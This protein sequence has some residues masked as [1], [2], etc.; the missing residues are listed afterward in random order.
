M[1]GN[2]TIQRKMI[3]VVLAVAVAFVGIFS[4]ISIR[5][6]QGNARVINY[7]GVV[8]GGTQKLIKEELQGTQDDA[9]I[10]R[11]DDIIEELLTG[12]GELG[13]IRLNDK[14]FQSLMT[15]MKDRFQELKEAIMSVRQGGDK[16]ALFVISQEYFELADQTVTEAEQ[17]SEKNAEIAEIC[18]LAL[19]AFFIVVA[20]A[21][22]W[23]SSVQSKRQKVLQEAEAE[24]RKKQE[25]LSQMERAIQA[26]M[27][28]IS[29]LIYVSDLE[30]Y[31]LLF[32]NEAGKKTFH[33]DDIS[34]KKCYKVLQ[35]MDSP[36]SFCT[37]G[38]LKPG[39]NY[40]WE[41]TNPLTKCH[42]M[43]K[44]RLIEWD[45]RKARMEIAFD[46]TQVETEKEK[47]K[48][49]LDME[50]MVVECIRILYQG[51]DLDKA[52]DQVLRL[53]G[54]FLQAERT[55]I[56]SFKDD[57]LNNDYEWCR[58]GV[59]P[60]KEMLQN[61]PI[62]IIDR[63][64]PVFSE[65]KCVVIEDVEAYKDSSPEE[66]EALKVQNI[67]SL[68]VAPMETDGVLTGA[69][70][71]DNPPAEKIENISAP[72]QSLCYFLLLAYR[73]TENERQLSTLSFHDTLTSFYN[74]NK[75]MQDLEMLSRENSPVGIVY[76][77][78]NGLK[79]VNDRLGHS[80]GDRLLI[81]AADKMKSVF[82]KDDCYRVGG[83][84]FVII[85]LNI[86][87][88]MF[89]EKVA[90]LRRS[91]EYEDECRAAIGSR[92]SDSAL[93]INQIVA[94][95]DAS[96]Y[97][98][99]KLFYR[100]NKKAGR[101][102]HHS[103]EVLQLANPVVLQGEI[104]KQQFVVYLQPKISSSDRTAVGAEALIRYLSKDG[105]L[106]LPGH[107]L[108]VLEEAKTISQIDFYVFDLVCAKI[109]EWL[110]GG[111]RSVPVSVNFSRFSLTQPN[112]LERLKEICQKHGISPT[113]LEIE[114]TEYVGDVEGTDISR[115]ITALRGEGFGVTIDDFGTNYA[116][117]SL[118]SA[119]EFDVL[120]L[121]R[122]MVRDVAENGKTREIIKAI[123][124][125]C[126]KMKIKLVA[127]GIE[128]EEQLEA[129]KSCGVELV[130]GYLFSEPIPI[131]EYE[132][133]YLQ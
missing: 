122:S 85:S 58:Q 69:L 106:V 93:N 24:N 9:L 47:L 63:W 36:C 10:R 55:Y 89:G 45:G 67:K 115:L 125:I 129:L 114:I 108:P 7:A 107:F 54:E 32:I 41:I 53:V 57:M 35:G 130:Q 118:L 79:E 61:L 98:D 126:K 60:Q 59:E 73:R 21:L 71:V 11:L 49:A 75:Y 76:L 84:E 133:E 23:L 83:D 92:W 16:E 26:P 103:D 113:H 39:E 131:E 48:Y 13:L 124:D 94:D 100:K 65:Q 15:Q 128:K 96:M 62:S 28:E 17:Y 27:N 52:V 99:K 110:E 81:R 66:Y 29:E 91:F 74:R 3:V 95:A 101:Y 37:N 5:K 19:T 30:N 102:R 121:D 70:G 120:K 80:E 20:C 68:V 72:L 6:L 56:F 132:K 111:K 25:R 77:D 119:V 112:F 105:S 33:V 38:R 31:D 22:V 4:F 86:S 87:E 42:Y 78:V 1:T 104:D 117:L 50:N 123:V 12:E 34:G 14:D 40:N 46:M 88:E 51:R 44:D 82:R 116:N 97:E 8:R 127:E 43:L 90:E 64:L 18:S 109:K 2:S